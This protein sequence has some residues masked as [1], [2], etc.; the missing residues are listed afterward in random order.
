MSQIV[1]PAVG[2]GATLAYPQDRCPY[3]VVAVGARTVKVLPLRTDGLDPTGQ[4]NG[5]PVFDYV[6][7]AEQI[8]ER[9]QLNML[10][11]TAYRRKCGNFYLGGTLLLVGRARYFR[12]FAD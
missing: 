10:P 2:M 11:K 6:F 3:V 8:T 12:N 1:I 7:S 4:C 5:F 9:V